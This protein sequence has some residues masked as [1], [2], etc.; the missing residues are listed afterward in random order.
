MIVKE[1]RGKK[2]VMKQLQYGG[3]FL[4]EAVLKFSSF[5]AFIKAKVFQ[6]FKLN[7]YC[8][9]FLLKLFFFLKQW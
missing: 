2:D 9:I 6:F 5:S 3:Q 4:L 1:Q 8:S 7:L